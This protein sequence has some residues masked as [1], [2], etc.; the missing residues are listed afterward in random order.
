MVLFS[1]V[2]WR[3][4]GIKH[5]ANEIY[6]DV[7]EHVDGILDATGKPVSL[8]VFGEICADVSLS[9]ETKK[10]RERMFFGFN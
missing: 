9:G 5:T 2:L 4:R 1:L 8:E 3:K 10:K 6:L 7:H